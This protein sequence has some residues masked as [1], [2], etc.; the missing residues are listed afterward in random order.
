MERAK[1]KQRDFSLDL[2][3]RL[4][5]SQ[6]ITNTT[7]LNQQV[8]FSRPQLLLR[9]LACAIFQFTCVSV[10]LGW[11]SVLNLAVQGFVSPLTLW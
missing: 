5:K 6:V 2:T 10:P 7:P 8:L 9:S 1:L 4:G 11:P 3:S